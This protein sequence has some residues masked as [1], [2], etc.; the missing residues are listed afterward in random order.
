M[1]CTYT[2]YYHVSTVL[3]TDKGCTSALDF[4]RLV[5]VQC[6]YRTSD[7]PLSALFYVFAGMESLQRLA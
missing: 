4:E 6:M 2:V 5:C 1:Y 3:C 7:L